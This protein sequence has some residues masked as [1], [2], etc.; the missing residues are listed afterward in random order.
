MKYSDNFTATFSAGVT[1]STTSGGGYKI[2]TVT[3]T[4]TGAETVSFS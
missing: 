2:T 3:A 1:H 4:S